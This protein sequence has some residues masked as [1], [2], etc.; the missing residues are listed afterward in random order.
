[1]TTI[2]QPA[3]IRRRVEDYGLLT[4]RARFV[5]DI[6][7]SGRPP[8]L[9]V[10]LVRSPYAHAAIRGINLD[11]AR[12]LPGVV[13]AF[14]GE[15]LATTL[16]PIFAVP[17]PGLKRPEKRALAIDKVR[18]V[19]EPVAVIVAESLAAA[20]DALE[21]VE[22]DYEPLPAVSDPEEA[23]APEAPL[24]YPEFGSNI[25][26]E[27]PFKAGDV[28]GIFA[29]APH[30][31]RLRLENQRLAPSSLENRACLFDFDAATGRLSAWLS[32]QAV[33]QAHQVLAD[34][35]GLEHR[36]VEVHNAMSGGG[37]GAKTRLGGEEIICAALALRLGRPVK[38]IESRRENLQA[39][40]HGRGQINYVEAAYDDEGHLLA[41]RLRTIADLG[42]YLLG[43]T[44]LVPIRTPRL[45]SGA[46][47]L[48][49]LESTVIGVF[50]N[51]VPTMAYRGAGRPE[52]SYIV[53]R[54]IDRIAA[55]LG[56]DP[57]EV[58]RRNFIPPEA[59]PYETIT[60]QHYDSGN[61]QAALAHLLELADYQGWRAR[62]R[63]RR[64]AGDP[65][66]LGIGLATFTEIS[67][68]EGG[69][70]REAATVRIL[71]DGTILVESGVSSTGQG[72]AT[73]FTQ[74]A[75]EVFNVSPERVTVH[76]NDSRLPAFSIGTFA[77]RV[78]QMG[79][80]VVLLAAQALRE[81]VLQLAAQVLE[82]APA[83]LLLQD[84]RVMVQGAPTRAITLGELA[85]LAEEQP[86]LLAE[87][88]ARQDTSPFEGLAARR[89]FASGPTFSFGAHMAV[90]EI[91][92]ETGE[93]HPLSYVA[94]DDAGRILNHTLAE[95]QLHG[96][97]AQGI[98]QALY[99]QVYYDEN[100]QLLSGTLQDYALPLATM[101]PAFTT[102]FVETPSPN[103][104]L[105]AKGIGE[106]GT[107]GAPPAIVN[108]VLD[109]LAPL[110]IKEIDMPVT[111]EKVWRAIQAAR[112]GAKG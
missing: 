85:R 56:L 68:D 48:E 104:P 67:G 59:F 93:V 111:P 99:E 63:E 98:G 87:E 6:R 49:A 83:D 27:V 13:A 88:R 84:G 8:I 10:A 54:V 65:R 28:D 61:Y 82:V 37:F 20:S 25:A 78:T 34:A 38:W 2:E 43:I 86:T 41:M 57:V 76:L 95:G 12:K 52:A 11:E 71:R 90:V 24:L 22:V 80:S 44:A 9:H 40:T 66:L 18:Y 15:E 107:I 4:G 105:G 74:L 1:M 109:A 46:Y 75:A 51:K 97:L 47:R 112:D 96:G 26:C 62:Q 58:R 69:Q 108:A 101:V 5:D 30:I 35:L 21:L 32:S 19:G 60:G 3:E 72:H 36:C 14:A 42:A 100:G 92:S 39:Q 29:R 33:Y 102:A 31:T 94:V 7:L 23:L 79:G 17:M 106:S 110:G 73:I 50:T 53:E 89:D 91:D 70:P 103:N 45:A 55:E 64:A 77:S 16:P 81:K